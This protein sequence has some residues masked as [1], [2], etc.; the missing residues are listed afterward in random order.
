MN[1]LINL[2]ANDNIAAEAGRVT[3]ANSNRKVDT[4]GIDKL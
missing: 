3:H 1:Y 2:I 4:Y